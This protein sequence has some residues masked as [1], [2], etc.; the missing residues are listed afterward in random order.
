V[1]DGGEDDI[2]GIAL[3]ALEVT[4]ALCVRRSSCDDH[5]LDG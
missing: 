2:G 5:G 1:A 4:V 3:T